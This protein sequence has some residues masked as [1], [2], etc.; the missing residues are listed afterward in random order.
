MY[1]VVYTI[2]L[3]QF[4]NFLCNFSVAASVI[5]ALCL[6]GVSF[7]GCNRVLGVI[8]MTIA[9]TSLAG[10]YCGFLAN[11]IDIAPNF[12]GTLVAITNTIA[13]IPGLVVPILVGKLTEGNVSKRSPT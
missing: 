5:P 13:T 9:V 8:L 2:K 4:L 1:I 11:H 12:A 7:V 3:K 10:M 6:I